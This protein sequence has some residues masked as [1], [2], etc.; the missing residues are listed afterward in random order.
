MFVLKDTHSKLFIPTAPRPSPVG[1]RE[2]EDTDHRG[3]G[4]DKVR[5]NF[6]NNQFLFSFNSI[7]GGRGGMASTTRMAHCEKWNEALL[8]GDA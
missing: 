6:K 3:T 8:F 1:A 5:F 4:D 7:C 2:N